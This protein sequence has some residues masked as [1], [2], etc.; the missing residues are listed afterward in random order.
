MPRRRRQPPVENGRANLRQR[1]AEQPNNDEPPARRQ[2][3]QPRAN[4]VQNNQ[5]AEVQPAENEPAN[6]PQGHIMQAQNQQAPQNIIPQVQPLGEV[7]INFEQ[8]LLIPNIN[9]V[10]IFINQSI[11]EKVWSFQYVDLALLHKSNIYRLDQQ[12]VISVDA[13]DKQVAETKLA[14]TKAINNIEAWT[15]AF[16]SYSQVLIERHPHKAS[17]LFS[18]FAIIRSAA[19]Q[20][21]IEKWYTYDQQFRLRVARDHAKNWGCIDSQLW[22]QFVALGIQKPQMQTDNKCYDFNFKG[23][24]HRYN[25]FYKH[26]CIKCFMNHPAVMCRKYFGYEVK[27]NFRFPANRP[28]RPLLPRPPRAGFNFGNRIR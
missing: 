14:K 6:Q 22:L 4:P 25:C 2:R 28:P 1:G 24:C 20:C 9:E 15:D 3:L 27:Q 13:N 5:P 23:E 10:D 26:I 11:K 8:P 17:Q 19:I 18:Y 7:N 12:Q 16:I 21:S